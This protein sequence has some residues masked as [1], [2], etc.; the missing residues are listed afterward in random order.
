MGHRALVAYERLDS[1]YNLHYS[2]W[3]AHNLRLKH[4]IT[5]E[6]P[7]GME[8]AV[9]GTRDCFEA[10]LGAADTDAANE[11]V[12]DADLQHARVNHEPRAVAVSFQTILEEYLDFLHHEAVYVVDVDFE[13]TAYRTHWFG[14]DYDSESITAEP[15]VGNGLLR[16]VRWHDGT[17]VDDSY[18]NGEFRGLKAVVGDMVDWGVFTPET[19]RDYLYLKLRELMPD[20]QSVIAAKPDSP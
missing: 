5:P 1:L 4:A 18:T 2:H 10:L 8:T 9:P 7:F 11:I 19:A 16:T 20:D 6:T 13:V 12:A 14:L 3:G 15:T 17:P